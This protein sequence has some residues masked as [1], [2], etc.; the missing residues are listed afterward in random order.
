MR[1]R[2]VFR[3]TIHQFSMLPIEEVRAGRLEGF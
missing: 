2:E 3:L 1:K